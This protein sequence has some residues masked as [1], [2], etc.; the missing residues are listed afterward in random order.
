[1]KTIIVPTDFSEQAEHALKYALEFVKG[2]DFHRIILFHSYQL[3]F[4]DPML[5][6][7]VNYSQL[8]V[9]QELSSQ[10]LTQL[11]EKYQPK[12]TAIIE[13]VSEVGEFV[14]GVKR[15]AKKRQASLIIMGTKG[16]SG[17]KEIVIGSNTASIIGQVSIPVLAIP[18][19]AK[20]RK[21]KRIVYATDYHSGDLKAL[22]YILP[23]AQLFGARIDL[24]HMAAEDSSY[25]EEHEQFVKYTNKI[26]SK[27]QYKSLHFY[28][29][30]GVELE[31]SLE[32]Y[33]EKEQVNLLALSTKH[34]GLLERLFGKSS[35]TQKLAYHVHI[36]LLAFHYK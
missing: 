21:I 26:K 9:L 12:T 19:E 24:I 22:K 36:P 17:L 23:I 27:V 5:G 31:R 6:S 11:I 18:A 16:A 29:L 8:E 4:A 32:K 30:F 13:A 1:M 34:R 7:E 15:I 25:S 28:L 10:K 20:Y 14:S 3:I 2:E 33:I 35:F